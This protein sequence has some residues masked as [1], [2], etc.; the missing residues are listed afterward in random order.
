VR[1]FQYALVKHTFVVAGFSV[2]EM[3]DDRELDSG[4]ILRG[5]G[6]AYRG[7]HEMFVAGYGPTGFVCGN[8]YGVDY[9]DRGWLT[10]PYALWPL[11]CIGGRAII[12]TGAV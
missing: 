2:D 4:F 11:V 12:P 5:V 6:T 8:S 9:A 7:A 3:W 10:I 1:S